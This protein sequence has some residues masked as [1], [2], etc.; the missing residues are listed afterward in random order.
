MNVDDARTKLRRAANET[1]FDDAKD[2]ARRASNALDDAAMSAMDC[3]CQ[4]A[5]LEF[6]TAAFRARRARDADSPHEFVEYLNGA[7]RAFNAAI[8]VL[9]ICI[10][11]RTR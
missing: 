2:N 9:R 10:N 3:G 5:Y 1:D 11:T 8:D 7:I 4:L 6:D